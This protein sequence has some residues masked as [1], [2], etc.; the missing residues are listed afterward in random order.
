MKKIILFCLMMGIKGVFSQIHPVTKESSIHFT[1]HNFGLKVSGI[2]DPPEGDIL[3]I[4]EDLDKSYFRIT[5]K[6]MSVNTNNETRDR[7]LREENYLDVKN[8]PE[9]HFVSESIRITD[10]NGS[11]EA[12]G[13]LTIKKTSKE[14]I[15]PF[16]VEKSDVGYTFSGNLKINRK[17]YGIGGASTISNELTVDIHVVAR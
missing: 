13:T 12:V 17:D 5:L 4:P 15:L 7:H 11:Y 2:L 3:F 1:I 8:F 6:S 16:T 14:I 9:I 10:K